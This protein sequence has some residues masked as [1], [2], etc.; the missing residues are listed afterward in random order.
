MTYE[1]KNKKIEEIIKKYFDRRKG[2]FTSS[3]INNYS[4][5]AHVLQYFTD[6]DFDTLRDIIQEIE[7]SNI[8]IKIKHT[9][10]KKGK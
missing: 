9:E 1:E 10:N 8:C 5:V 4:M 7:N 2:K 3:W 6:A